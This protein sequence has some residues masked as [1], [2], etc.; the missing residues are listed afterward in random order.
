MTTASSGS[1]GNGMNESYFLIVSFRSKEG[2]FRK[3][4]G[5][6]TGNREVRKKGKC[7]E[8]KV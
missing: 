1:D 4:F 5:A 3:N 2:A 7:E 6:I 8:E